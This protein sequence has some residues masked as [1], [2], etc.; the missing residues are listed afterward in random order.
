MES[1]IKSIIKS[2]QHSMIVEFGKHK[3]FSQFY[4]NILNSVSKNL[5]ISKAEIETVLVDYYWL[6]HN[7]VL[8]GFRPS[9]K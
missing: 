8:I 3:N 1:I 5:N 7:K 6:R 4:E 2:I 9:D